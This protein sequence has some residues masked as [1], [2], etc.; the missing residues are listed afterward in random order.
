[1]VLFLGFLLALGALGMKLSNVTVLA[2]ACGIGLGF[3][4]QG[5]PNCSTQR[6]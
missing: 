1:M 3:G 2:R 6:V 5:V 4:I